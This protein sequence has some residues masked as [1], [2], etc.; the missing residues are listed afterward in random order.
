MSTHQLQP[1]FERETIIPLI[2]TCRILSACNESLLTEW[3]TQ[4]PKLFNDNNCYHL[5]LKLLTEGLC[6]HHAS[7]PS[8]L[9]EQMRALLPQEKQLTIDDSITKSDMTPK[10]KKKRGKK[11]KIVLVLQGKK[12]PIT[13]LKVPK[14]LKMMIFSFVKR[15]DLY[16]LQNVCRCFN[17]AARDPNA[18]HPRLQIFKYNPNYLHPFFSKINDLYLMQHSC[19]DKCTIIKFNRHWSTSLIHLNLR[20]D[21][22]SDMHDFGGHLIN[23]ETLKLDMRGHSPLLFIRNHIHCRTLKCLQITE[24]YSQSSSFNDEFVMAISNCINLET[25]SLNMDRIQ[26]QQSKLFAEPNPFKKL[27]DVTLSIY[28]FNAPSFYHWILKGH[29]QKKL[30]VKCRSHPGRDFLMSP[31]FFNKENVNA[32]SAVNNIS[33]ITIDSRCTQHLDPFIQ[34]LACCGKVLNKRFNS[35][36]LRLSSLGHSD[37]GTNEIME[38]AHGILLFCGSS[39]LTLNLDLG[40]IDELTTT[41]TEDNRMD[42]MGF[43]SI[44]QKHP[45]TFD[46]LCVDIDCFWSRSPTYYSMD[47]WEELDDG[48]NGLALSRIGEEIGSKLL[49]YHQ[50]WMY[51]FSTINETKMRHIGLKQISSEFHCTFEISFESIFGM[52]F[53]YD[54]D[55]DRKS[56]DKIMRT[57]NEKIYPSISGIIKKQ[58]DGQCVFKESNGDIVFQFVREI[59]P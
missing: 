47:I 33:D 7:I 3:L 44:I 25:L 23:L 11:Q 55:F 13:F 19:L 46:K 34:N 2:Q 45:K 1:N 16:S 12:E 4:I 31:E 24:C 21:S 43:M 9:Y 35:M 57:W 42:M 6:R 32:L 14:D 17:L 41:F 22:R 28:F 20:L 39:S 27:V 49:E 53:E 58:I 38:A 29:R 40:N 15:T 18:L 5:L 59:A 26:S 51:P 30:Y 56:E 37:E 36:Y 8:A 48:M 10:R 50:L 54:D 52:D